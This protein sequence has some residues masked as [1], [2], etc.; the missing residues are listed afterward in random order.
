VEKIAKTTIKILVMRR[1]LIIVLHAT[2]KE[3]QPP[4]RYNHR[5]RRSFDHDI[6]GLRREFSLNEFTTW[7]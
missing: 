4:V 5:S 3:G 2:S 1:G 6:C 7:D